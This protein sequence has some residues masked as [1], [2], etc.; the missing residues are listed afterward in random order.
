MLKSVFIS[1]VSIECNAKHSVFSIFF[2]VL[3]QKYG[4]ELPKIEEDP[5]YEMFSEIKD[6]RQIFFGLEPGW[7]INLPDQ[8]IIK[9]ISGSQSQEQTETKA[10]ATA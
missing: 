8:S 9:P 6:P 10:E 2:Q 5:H 3:A 4:Y 1:K 7:V